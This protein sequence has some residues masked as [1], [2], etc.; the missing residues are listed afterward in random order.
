MT[1]IIDMNC[2]IFKIFYYLCS[3]FTSTVW[4]KADE[5]LAF[6]AVIDVMSPYFIHPKAG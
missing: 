6:Y 3:R 2:Y 4:N 5:L 1:I